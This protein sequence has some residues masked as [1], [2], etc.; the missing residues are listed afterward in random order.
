M[1]MMMMLMLIYGRHRRRLM[2]ARSG[3][4][5]LFSLSSRSRRSRPSELIRPRFL[6]HTTLSLMTISQPG[7]QCD[8][9]S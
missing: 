1:V 7:H 8:V 3:P 6:N 5:T 4:W 2:L 9:Q